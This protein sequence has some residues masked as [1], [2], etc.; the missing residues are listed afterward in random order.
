MR[1]LSLLLLV[2]IGM[3]YVSVALAASWHNYPGGVALERV[4]A[5][6]AAAGAAGAPRSRVVTAFGASRR[7][8]A[9]TDAASASKDASSASKDAASASSDAWSPFELAKARGADWFVYVDTDASM[10]GGSRFGEVSHAV[11]VDPSGSSHPL[12]NASTGLGSASA[13]SSST[14]SSPFTFY[15]KDKLLFPHT[16]ATIGRHDVFQSAY[17]SVDSPAA[18]RDRDTV[19]IVVSGTDPSEWQRLG[20]RVAP[21]LGVVHAF[22]RLSIKGVTE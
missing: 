11:A 15:T 22:Q 6:I 5:V 16:A 2:T 4:R 3:V 14:I 9:S 19:D 17:T 21:W 18:V 1:W 13:S 20:F 10:T 8:M 12:S 7:S